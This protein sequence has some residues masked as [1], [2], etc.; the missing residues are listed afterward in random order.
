MCYQLVERYSICRCLY[1]RHSVDPCEIYGQRGHTVTERAVLVGWVCP[2]HTARHS[3][4]LSQRFLH[5]DTAESTHELATARHTVRRSE[6]LAQRLPH[7]DTAESIHEL[8][9]ARHTI[10]RLEG[11]AQRFP[12]RDTAESIHELA[13]EEVLPEGPIPD[14]ASEDATSSLVDSDTYSAAELSTDA[15]SLSRS[16]DH[17]Q[18]ANNAAE[19]LGELFYAHEI[20]GPLLHIGFEVDSF[21]FGDYFT[22]L[23]QQYSA[24]LRKDVSNTLEMGAYRLVRSRAPLISRAVQSR[25]G[26]PLASLFDDT[27]KRRKRLEDGLKRLRDFESDSDEDEEDSYPTLSSISRFIF[28][29]KAF[30]KLTRELRQHPHQVGQPETEGDILTASGE[31]AEERDD[32]NDAVAEGSLGRCPDFTAMKRVFCKLLFL[33]RPSEPPLKH[34]KARIRWKCRCG[35]IIYDDYEELIPGAAKALQGHF[36]NY[37]NQFPENA[38]ESG[39]IKS[40]GRGLGSL[41]TTWNSLFRRSR[42]NKEELPLSKIRTRTLQPQPNS[43]LL[44]LLTC[45]KVGT[46]PTLAQKNVCNI[47]SDQDFFHLLQS[48]R[49]NYRSRYRSIFAFDKVVK[50]N[51]VHFEL[52]P[53]NLVN[54]LTE[55]CPPVDSGYTP[56]KDSFATFP[57]ISS[58]IMIHLYENPDHADISKLL[59]SRIPKKLDSELQICPIK[60]YGHGWGLEL[61]DGLNWK[62]V[63][64]VGFIGLVLSC[65]FGILWSVL[66]HDVQG[67]WAITACMMMIIP[68]FTG[69][70]HSTYVV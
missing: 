56:V 64:V 50:I 11:L 1:H 22:R 19:E 60:R 30:R 57:P 37:S 32:E 25:L 12:H 54:I 68:F 61:V 65:A 66:R 33:F 24:E 14:T 35:K 52:L 8:A 17:L 63:W 16:L 67:G 62:K 3:E 70:L 58:N 41:S 21:E 43:R 34:G 44:F 51:F 69:A 7:R 9:T 59:T 49:R 20:V 26:Y 40:I 55:D 15:S 10:K 5:R 18:N 28:D 27:R 29:G 53:N 6:D 38:N 45:L 4:G 46:A 42:E 36:N 31:G 2:R 23:L 39:V 47:T 13:T 48:Q